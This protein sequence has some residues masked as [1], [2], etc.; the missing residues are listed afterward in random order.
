M[1]KSSEVK[2]CPPSL[3]ALDSKIRDQ[4]QQQAIQ[5]ALVKRQALEKQ[6]ADEVSAPAESCSRTVS[7][8]LWASS[9]ET[10][11]DSSQQNPFPALSLALSDPPASRISDTA[12]P[13]SRTTETQTAVVQTTFQAQQTQQEVHSVYTQAGGGLTLVSVSIQTEPMQEQ[14]T[15]HAARPGYQPIVP[16][17]NPNPLQPKQPQ[18]QPIELRAALDPNLQPPPYESPSHQSVQHHHLPHSQRPLHSNPTPSTAT[19]HQQNYRPTTDPTLDHNPFPPIAPP[20]NTTALSQ[21]QFPPSAPANVRKPPTHNPFPP[22]PATTPNSFNASH[23]MPNG[24][25]AAASPPDPFP[26]YPVQQSNVGAR[27]ALPKEPQAQAP[28]QDILPAYPAPVQSKDQALPPY[29][30]YNE[31][32]APLSGQP[33]VL[34]GAPPRSIDAQHHQQQQQQHGVPTVPSH[35]YPHTTTEQLAAFSDRGSAAV[36]LQPFDRPVTQPPQRPPGAL[37]ST[38][39]VLQ[40]R[41]E[42]DIF[43]A[44]SRPTMPPPMEPSMALASATPSEGQVHG[45]PQYSNAFPPPAAHR[46]DPRT[47]APQGHLPLPAPEPSPSP[48]QQQGAV[49]KL[50]PMGSIDSHATGVP[51]YSA[52]PPADVQQPMHSMNPPSNPPRPEPGSA[53]SQQQVPP[54]DSLGGPPQYSH[55][56][57]SSQPPPQYS[58][59]TGS[60]VHLQQSAPQALPPNA[61]QSHTQA[62]HHY[63]HNEVPPLPYKQ[64]DP[65]RGHPHPLHPTVPPA[66][67]H[68]STAVS[69]AFPPGPSTAM[70]GG[71]GGSRLPP[72]PHQQPP[73]RRLQQDDAAAFP[74]SGYRT[75]PSAA[76]FR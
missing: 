65:V 44:P 2:H 4:I 63:T 28:P 9:S 67:T 64:P 10:A 36:A 13:P 68:A 54:N 32:G 18:Q 50:P 1:V 53:F 19:P 16:P 33:G 20:V 49:Q 73:P 55:S 62:H 12:P 27:Q 75:G 6:T 8:S 52:A 5:T 24:P 41:Q 60:S 57:Y 42:E 58:Q 40:A 37:H 22:V 76:G 14:P 45:A 21:H 11:A 48:L 15:S 39:F 17:V 71:G 34:L 56:H 3:R 31:G 30:Y 72:H 61:L 66:S 23:T 70:G 29:R 38:H 69:A 26:P 46:F 59:P 25:P 47:T 51:P 7:N 74:S 43:Y 35:L